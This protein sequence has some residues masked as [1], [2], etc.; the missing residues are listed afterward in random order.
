MRILAVCG[1]LQTSSSNKTL[2]QAAAGLVPPGVELSIFD[3]LRELPHF[4]PDLEEGGPLPVVQAWRTAVAESAAV[5]I[6]CPEYGFSLPGVIKNGID[7][8][9]GSGELERKVIAI[10]ASVNH[11]DRGRRGLGA[12]R[13]TLNAVSARIVGGEPLVRGPGQEQALA[14]LLG[15]LVEAAR[16]AAEER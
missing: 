2:L 9:I 1:S 11:P 10:T 12:L 5:L 15:E 13:D 8:A 14:A 7:W 3:G 4:N 6:A 16:Q